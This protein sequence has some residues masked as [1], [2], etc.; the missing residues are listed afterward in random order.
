MGQPATRE[1]LRRAGQII[2]ARRLA[3]GLRQEDL[4]ERVHVSRPLISNYE[5]GTV[6]TP[7][8]AVLAR[9]ERALGLAE[10]TLRQIA[11]GV[12]SPTIIIDDHEHQIDPTLHRIVDAY[13]S[14]RSPE[15]RRKLAEYVEIYVAGMQRKEKEHDES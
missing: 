8:P 4:A 1:G 7:D 5:R 6:Q 2:R 13:S 9:L 3:L 12:P 10:G 11:Y 15:A 14:L